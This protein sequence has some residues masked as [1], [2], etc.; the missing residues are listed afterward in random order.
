M[1]FNTLLTI[2]FF[3]IRAHNKK[4]LEKFTFY[5]SKEDQWKTVVHNVTYF[6]ERS[7]VSKVETLVEYSNIGGRVPNTS[8]R[9]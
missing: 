9:I 6:K 8:E 1:S 2:F 3:P 7:L 4:L 5:S